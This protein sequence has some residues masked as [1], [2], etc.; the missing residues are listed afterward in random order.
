MTKR[1]KTVLAAIALL[2]GAQV[3]AEDISPGYVGANWG[4]RS[5]YSI[6]CT[7]GEDCSYD[8][9]R[10]GKVY[11]GYTLDSRT[12]LG[13]HKVTDAVEL[14]A[15]WINGKYITDSA[16]IFRDRPKTQGLALTFAPQMEL[17]SGLSLNSR[18]GVAY[19]RTR[20]DQHTTGYPD[21][22]SNTFERVGFTAGLGLSYAVNRNWSL[23]MDYDR[24]P[25]KYSS[26][27]GNG[28]INMWS[29]GA[30][31]HF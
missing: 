24:I 29:V 9:N 25:V 12:T 23:R 16:G 22:Q 10:G 8:S 28:Q 30:A 11:A 19:S 21:T 27:A 31:Y 26:P 18:V 17:G 4:V 1:S 13:D 3:R 7:P 6:G 20:F 14:S 15:F 2:A 5:N